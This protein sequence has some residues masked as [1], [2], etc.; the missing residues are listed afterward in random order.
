MNLGSCEVK[1]KCVDCGTVIESVKDIVVRTHDIGDG[2][3]VSE[4]VCDECNNARE[5]YIRSLEWL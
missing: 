1:F 4:I 3:T 2:D 5:R